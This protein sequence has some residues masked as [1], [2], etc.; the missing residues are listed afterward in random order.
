M[1]I[2]FL[3]RPLALTRMQRHSP[4]AEGLRTALSP[5]LLPE[6]GRLNVRAGR[7]MAPTLASPLHGAA[8]WREPPLGCCGVGAPAS[9][10]LLLTAAFAHAGSRPAPS[11]RA[12]EGT[13][14]IVSPHCLHASI[15]PP[16]GSTPHSPLVRLARPLRAAMDT[17]VELP[18]TPRHRSL[19]AG[20]GKRVPS[21]EEESAPT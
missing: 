10:P 14:L 16:A 21:S 18:S 2:L 4:A 19:A 13:I 12:Q 5:S 1:R 3:E 6:K 15:A 20:S 7:P 17:Q 11:R 8:S 9:A